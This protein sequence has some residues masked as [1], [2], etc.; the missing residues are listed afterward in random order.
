M[1]CSPV[2]SNAFSQPV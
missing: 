1:N 2:P